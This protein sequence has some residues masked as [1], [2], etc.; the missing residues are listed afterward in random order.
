MTSGIDELWELNQP[1]LRFGDMASVDVQSGY[2]L[3]GSGN[4]EEEEDIDDAPICLQD[5]LKQVTKDWTTLKNAKPRAVWANFVAS[6]L[7][8]G[9]ELPLDVQSFSIR[10]HYDKAWAES[11][12]EV[13]PPTAPSFRASEFLDFHIQSTT[14]EL[15]LFEL[16]FTNE[17]VEYLV[18]QTNA[19]I[20]QGVRRCFS[21]LFDRLV[22][23]SGRLC[24]LTVSS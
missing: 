15:E 4:Q 6:H 2:L 23:V 11:V 7:A 5:R 20:T 1:V 22:G 12:H 18:G 8:G 21:L 17:I 13:K 24:V 16:L 3:D 9:K 14:S 19:Y 10:E